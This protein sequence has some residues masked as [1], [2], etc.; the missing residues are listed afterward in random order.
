MVS[1]STTRRT[2]ARSL[3]TSGIGGAQRYR[4]SC[5]LLR[6]Q[7]PSRGRGCSRRRGR[8][9][10]RRGGAGPR[11]G[12]CSG[13]TVG[14][15]P[16]WRS[17]RSP[18][19]RGR[20]RWTPAAR[21]PRAA[22]TRTATASAPMRRSGI[23]PSRR[24]SGRCRGRGRRCGS[25]PPSRSCLLRRKLVTFLPLVLSTAFAVPTPCGNFLLK[26]VQ[27]S[28]MPVSCAAEAVPL[29]VRTRPAAARA[30]ASLRRVMWVPWDGVGRWSI[31]Q[32]ILVT[33]SANLSRD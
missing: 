18:C 1:P 6:C 26:F 23:R 9:R 13:R 5:P 3:R 30:A 28:W 32:A 14:R 8:H 29:S 2:F 20:P 11:R 16:G 31:G 7:H 25:R 12:C 33:R 24:R 4:G 22:P 15:P 10:R 19:R 27:L 17:R 21:G